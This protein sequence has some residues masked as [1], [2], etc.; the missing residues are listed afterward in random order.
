MRISS[1]VL[2]LLTTLTFTASFGLE[3]R[4]KVVLTPSGCP[5]S[6]LTVEIDPEQ[7]SSQ[8]KVITTTDANGSFDVSLADG[9]YLIQVFQLG[10]KVYQEIISGSNIVPLNVTVD[11]VNGNNDHGCA[12]PVPLQFSYTRNWRP[13]DLSYSND[14]GLL[15]LDDHGRVTEIYLSDQ[16]IT[17]KSLFSPTI[18]GRPI[19]VASG[20]NRVVVTSV[21][22]VGCSIYEYDV[23]AK[24]LTSRLLGPF[25]GPCSGVATN[26]VS[27]IVGFPQLS[28]IWFFPNSDFG[29]PRTI[30]MSGPSQS[31][32][33]ALDPKSTQLYIGDSN[34]TVY[35]SIFGDLSKPRKV[36][37]NAGPINSLTLSANYLLIASGSKVLC[38]KRRD[39]SLSN[40]SSCMDV[41]VSGQLSGIRVDN[42]DR[43]W[44][45]EKDRNTIMGPI[46][47][48]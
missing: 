6:G 28:E 1:V 7:G 8:A 29:R 36:I 48:K 11:S 33:F 16:R 2:F 25:S 17:A 34:G 10:R 19:S 40:L 5:I 45:L 21:L 22:P 39:F 31:Y 23:T 13:N 37:D 30:E 14:I 26:G 18:S 3:L 42:Q 46:P 38:Y 24:H 9:R 41:R 32:T 35:Q 27:T 20:A 43:A 12:Q 15:V 44:I 4:G 47:L